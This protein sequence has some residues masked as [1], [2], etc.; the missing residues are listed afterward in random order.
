MKSNSSFSSFNRPVVA[1]PAPDASNGLTGTGTV[2]S[3]IAPTTQVN[4]WGDKTLLNA[5]GWFKLRLTLSLK[6]E[7]VAANLAA[8]GNGTSG[9]VGSVCPMHNGFLRWS[10]KFSE[11]SRT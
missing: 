3:Q 2:A 4:E 8:I 10:S 7:G 1:S 6:G 5:G 11:T 9:S